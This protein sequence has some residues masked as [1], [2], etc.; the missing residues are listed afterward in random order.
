MMIGEGAYVVRSVML[1]FSIPIRSPFS[2]VPSSYVS[3]QLP[4]AESGSVG[5]L[6]DPVPAGSSMGALTTG[7]LLRGAEFGGAKA[8]VTSTCL[9]IETMIERSS[10]T[11]CDETAGLQINLSAVAL[12]IWP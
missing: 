8:V 5:R 4:S 7:G 2:V 6:A 9:V 3:S 12:T 10:V 11:S 1:P